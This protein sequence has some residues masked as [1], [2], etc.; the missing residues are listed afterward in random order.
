MMTQKTSCTLTTIIFSISII[1]Q[2]SLGAWS[3]DFLLNYFLNKDI[4]FW[5]D[6]VIGLFTAEITFP[7][8]IIVW[9]ISLF[10]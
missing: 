9:I 1:I 8:A 6:C 4:P 3:V 2:M 5:A 10:L 7:V